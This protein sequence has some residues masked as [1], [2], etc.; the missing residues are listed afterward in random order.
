[1]A[2]S[3]A[4]PQNREYSV[5]LYDLDGRQKVAVACHQNRTVDLARCSKFNHV[6]AEKD[7]DALL[8][9]DRGA[10]LPFATVFKFP[11]PN[12]EARQTRKCSDE[13][14]RVRKAGPLVGSR[15][16]ALKS[17][18]NKKGP[19]KLSLFRPHM[20]ARRPCERRG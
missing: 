13:S 11:E 8:S 10:I 20:L 12:L 3:S 2:T 17:R 7:V 18:H 14:F 1:M 19:A 5:S 9:E 15:E 6:D 16:A 4:V